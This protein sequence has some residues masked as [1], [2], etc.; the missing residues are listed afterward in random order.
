MSRLPA[1]RVHY[2]RVPGN[3]D[4]TFS[5][6]NCALVFMGMCRHLILAYISSPKYVDFVIALCD[7]TREQCRVWPP[8]KPVRVVGHTALFYVHNRRHI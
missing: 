2:Q 7:K 6:I 1:T 3:L 4:T 8:K 5:K